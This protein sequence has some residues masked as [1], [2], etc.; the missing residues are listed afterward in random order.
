ML[1]MNFIFLQVDNSWNPKY[2]EQL[3]SSENRKSKNTNHI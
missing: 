2:T 3:K 1:D